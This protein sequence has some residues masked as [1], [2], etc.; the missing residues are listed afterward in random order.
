MFASDLAI[1]VEWDLTT[2]SSEVV[3]LA[4]AATHSCVFASFTK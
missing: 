2:F 1:E 3:Y 4:Q